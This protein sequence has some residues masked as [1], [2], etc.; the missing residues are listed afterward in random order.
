[1]LASQQ[2]LSRG[3]RP[4]LAARRIIV[5]GAHVLG[6]PKGVQ[7]PHRR[8][9]Q[10]VQGEAVRGRPA[11]H[12]GV[13]AEEQARGLRAAGARH[14]QQLARQRHLGA[15]GVLRRRRTSAAGHELAS[16]WQELD[17]Q[18]SAPA[19]PCPGTRRAA[20]ARTAS[21]SR[22]RWP[23]RPGRRRRTR[24]GRRAAC[25]SARPPRR[26]Q[27][28]PRSCSADGAQAGPNA[29]SLPGACAVRARP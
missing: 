22:W 26:R 21:G 14:G 5:C 12:R 28:L 25:R 3:A 23:P 9:V 27:S 1:M 19:G 13:P 8:D 18:C 4:E 6:A 17:S 15:R 24:S 11:P 16:V 7:Q 2:A 10:L 20:A 29:C